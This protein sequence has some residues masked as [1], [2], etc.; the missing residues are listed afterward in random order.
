MA[1]R[2]YDNNTRRLQQL[3][4]KAHIAAVAAQLHSSQGVLA[5]TYAQIAERAGVAIPTVYKHFPS[6]D[7]LVRG[8]TA[9]V[10]GKA[11][12]FSAELILSAPDIKSAVQRLVEALDRLNAYFEPWVNWREQE[13]LPVLAEMG[14]HRRM[15]LTAL[16]AAVFKRHGSHGALPAAPAIWETLIHFETWQRLV[17]EHQLS[18]AA[19]RRTLVHL[20]LAVAGPQPAARS[21]PRPRTRK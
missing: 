12:E 17:R 16:C 9:H 13:R 14:A 15:E 7:E 5:T 2:A 19:V 6:L 18:R 21:T 4:L 1:P 8:C 11:P 20:L 10:V 3:A